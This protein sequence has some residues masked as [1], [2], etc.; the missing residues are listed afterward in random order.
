MNIQLP[1]FVRASGKTTRYPVSGDC[2]DECQ[3]LLQ[4][5]VL[6]VVAVQ[7]RLR[8]QPDGSVAY[9]EGWFVRLFNFCSTACARSAPKHLAE[10]KVR[11]TEPGQ[12]LATPC[13]GCG[14]MVDR[15][16]EAT[17]IVLDQV[18]LDGTDDDARTLF[19]FSVLC[20]SCAVWMEE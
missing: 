16:Q 11:T 8:P 4:D 10:G 12:A 1:P 18:R 6:A 14:Q 13:G 15:T 3:G 9:G 2:C 7:E 17:S 19:D 20:P 5:E